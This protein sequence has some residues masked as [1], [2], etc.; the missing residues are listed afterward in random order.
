MHNKEPEI[1]IVSIIRMGT[2]THRTV[3]GVGATTF[4]ETN[5]IVWVQLGEE[6]QNTN[7]TILETV[8]ELKAEMAR[9]QVD[10]ERLM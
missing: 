1:D 4:Q 3:T 7:S 5:P 2:I 6:L 8:Q 9:L 10:N